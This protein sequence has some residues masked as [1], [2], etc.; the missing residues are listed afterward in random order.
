MGINLLGR[1][2]KIS[3]DQKLLFGFV[4]YHRGTIYLKP[5][6]QDFEKEE[7][8]I[9]EAIAYATLQDRKVLFT[10]Y[11]P[12]ERRYKLY[13]ITKESTLEAVRNMP[14]PSPVDFSL[15]LG[16]S[17]KLKNFEDY[18]EYVL[19]DTVP[20]SRL[21]GDVIKTAV[22]V[23]RAMEKCVVFE[24]R[25]FCIVFHCMIT[26]DSTEQESMDLCTTIIEGDR[27]P[28]WKGDFEDEMRC[29][30]SQK[31]HNFFIESLE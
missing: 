7:E 3:R 24:F 30:E 17:P 15:I 20:Y 14:K 5:K 4:G 1:F 28:Y 11:D 13:I 12:E 26:P 29:E 31:I 6:D 9:N 18:G 19:C 27:F 8:L 16:C 2:G 25:W 22:K 23:A 21:I 10:L